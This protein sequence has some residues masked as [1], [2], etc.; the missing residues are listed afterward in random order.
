[1]IIITTIAVI[2]SEFMCIFIHVSWNLFHGNTSGNI[3]ELASLER[4]N[5]LM[6]LNVQKYNCNRLPALFVPN[7]NK[8]SLSLFPGNYQGI[9]NLTWGVSKTTHYAR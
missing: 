4:K 3:S 9:L 5:K 1:M 7:E 6:Y 2:S 8:L